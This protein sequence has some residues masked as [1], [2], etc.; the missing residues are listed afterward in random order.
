[1][2]HVHHP[3]LKCTAVASLLLAGVAAQATSWTVLSL[4]NLSPELNGGSHTLSNTGRIPG[5][6]YLT[7]HYAAYVSGPD[8]VGATALAAPANSNSMAKGLNEAGQAVGWVRIN[9]AP[10]RPFITN[11]NASGFTIFGD[12]GTTGVA[13]AINQSGQVVGYLSDINGDNAYVYITDSNA[14]G[15][16]AIVPPA[17]LQRMGNGVGINDL[18]QV[19]GSFCIDTAC[20]GQH[21]FVTAPNGQSAIDLG[22][23]GGNL[24]F[25]TSINASG[26]V[27]GMSL[28]GTGDLRGFVTGPYATGMR[29]I[30]TLGGNRTKAYDINTAGQIVGASNLAANA[31]QEHA[32]VTGPNGSNMVDLNTEV[33]PPNGGYFHTAQA[34]NDKGQVI[35]IADNGQAYLLT[36][37][38]NC[39]AS[40]KVLRKVGSYTYAEFS[41]TN[42][43]A[44]TQNGWTGSWQFGSTVKVTN[45]IGGSLTVS[46]TNLASAK[47]GTTSLVK[48]GAT[49]KMSYIVNSGANVLAVS[50]VQAKLGGQSCT[51]AP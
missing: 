39:S 26:V 19:T 44:Q 13:N 49:V 41:V 47:S 27:V 20:S 40:H 24:S 50:Q 3:I 38:P 32:F 35:A 8:G 10:S 14:Q 12:A 7:D 5:N 22:T 34:I 15:V 2:K 16:R 43:T 30:G 51:I 33:K 9:A 18:G 46:S 28:N 45:T 29:E 11:A 4:G 25:P 37:K 36:P 42:L 17:G 1:M 6:I 21:A 31:L 48:A 23:L